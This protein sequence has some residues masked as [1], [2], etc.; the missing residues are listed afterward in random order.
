MNRDNRSQ[1]NLQA[2]KAVFVETLPDKL[3]ELSIALKQCLDGTAGTDG[4]AGLT[5]YLEGL[6]ISASRFGFI[7]FSLRA[8]RIVGQLKPLLENHA[9]AGENFAP[10]GKELEELLRWAE[11]DPKSGVMARKRSRPSKPISELPET[12]VYLLNENALLAEDSAL[13][14]K[15]FGYDV[16]IVNNF[17]RLSIAI[18]QRM[19]AAIIVDLCHRGKS[20]LDVARI[21]SVRQI[22]NHRIPVIFLSTH[23]NFKARLAAVRAGADSYFTKPVDVVAL[24]DRLDALTVRKEMNPYRILIISD[25]PASAQ[26]HCMVL[27]DAGMDT[28]RL[29]DPTEIFRVLGDY[30]PEIVLMDV[31]RADC[32]SVDLAKLIRQNNMYLDVPIVFLSNGSD[33]SSRRSAIE[34]GGDDFHTKPIEPEQFISSLSN[35]ADRYRALRGLIMRDSL[36]G[37]Y[38]HSAIKEHL[39]REISRATRNSTPLALAMIDL[40]FFKKVNDSYG[41]PVGDQVIRTLSR[42]LQQRLRRSDIIG[43][44][45]GEEFAVIFPATSA[46]AA[47]GVLDR[48]REVFSKI[49][50]HADECEFTSSFT[51]GVAN[52]KE[53]LDAEALFCIADSA[54]YDA[55]HKGRNRIE[56]K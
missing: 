5:R 48:I 23:D 11:I 18:S 26:H 6:A 45:G 43:R 55:K 13:Q 25:D 52:L 51:A 33:A 53:D 22:G 46:W 40:D 2:L 17:D 7:E 20:L 10:I 27:K 1:E 16:V 50:H 36:T 41:H 34:S 37:L 39:I 31:D 4:P 8:H 14:L 21:E 3:R 30:R 42:L 29:H 28:K 32:S 35:R 24:V 38:N 19:P 15:Y 47:A 56:I 44:Y 9:N 54:L 12:P 49:R